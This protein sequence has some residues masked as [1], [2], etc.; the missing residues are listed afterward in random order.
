MEGVVNVEW[1][2]KDYL[3]LKWHVVCSGLATPDLK[4]RMYPQWDTA[5]VQAVFPFS[6]NLSQHV[7]CDVLNGGLDTSITPAVSVEVVERKHEVRW[8]GWPVVPVQNAVI[9]K[10]YAWWSN[11]A[12]DVLWRFTDHDWRRWEFVGKNN[13]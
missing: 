11:E 13:F 5:D 10:T 12:T 8:A 2:G 7:L 4:I 3:H 9:T 6:P 1:H